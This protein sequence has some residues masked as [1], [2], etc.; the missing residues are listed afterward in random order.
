[1]HLLRK[2]V[3]LALAAF[4]ALFPGCPTPSQS[5]GSLKGV[6]RIYVAET[7]GATT[8]E[9]TGATNAV[10]DA[11]VLALGV[12][13]YVVVPTAGQADAVLRSSWRIRQSETNSSNIP[14]VSLS[15]SLFDKS[16]HRLFDTDSGSSIPTTFWNESR[17]A[18]ETSGMLDRLT[19]AAV[20]QK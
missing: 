12:R 11:A 15:V 3:A 18:Q 17:A 7:I 20:Q 13:G 14:V 9:T 8:L 6:S 1:M 2:P 4:V 10:H 16:G 5:G 19:K